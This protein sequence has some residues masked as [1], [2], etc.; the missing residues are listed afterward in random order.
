MAPAP[1]TADRIDAIHRQ[2]LER[3]ADDDVPNGT[4]FQSARTQ[5][6]DTQQVT[7]SRLSTETA[8]AL[9][10]CAMNTR[11]KTT[12][13]TSTIAAVVLGIGAISSPALA[14]N[15]STIRGEKPSS[16][17]TDRAAPNA[18][19]DVTTGSIGTARGRSID[20]SAKDGNAELNDRSVPNYGATSGGPA[21]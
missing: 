17:F 7:A 4:S 19:D 9:L 5:F 1:G 21:E 20:R 8:Q 2:G 11:I 3:R 13:I 10:G 18:Y 12:R 16:F 15:F 6:R 14:Q